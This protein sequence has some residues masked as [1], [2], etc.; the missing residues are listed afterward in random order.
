MAFTFT[1]MV[2][3][4][5]FVIVFIPPKTYPT[6]LLTGL[7]IGGVLGFLQGMVAGLAFGRSNEATGDEEVE[8]LV[9]KLHRTIKGK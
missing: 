5:V 3:F 9:D 7:V 4:A 8:S 2:G 1:L 6:W